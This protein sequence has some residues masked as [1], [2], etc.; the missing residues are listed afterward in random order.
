[1]T[2]EELAA[3]TDRSAGELSG[4]LG[5]LGHR[6]NN[7]EGLKDLGATGVVLDWQRRGGSSWCRMRTVLPTLTTP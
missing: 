5:A 7:T 6:I 2:Q 3:A 4:V 1:M